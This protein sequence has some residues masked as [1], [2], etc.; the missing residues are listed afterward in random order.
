MAAGFLRAAADIFG[1][2]LWSAANASDHMKDAL[3]G[4]AHDEAFGTAVAEGRAHFHQCSRCHLWICPEAC[5]NAERSMC[6]K[7]APDLATEA[8]AAQ[9]QVAVEQAWEKT[10]KN[11]QTEDLDVAQK[12]VA[13]CPACGAKAPLSGKFC[14]ECGK[15]LAPPKKTACAKCNAKLAEGAKFCAECGERV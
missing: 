5:W 4:K 13:K 7:C 14:G 6:L 8:A 1:G 12:K 9:A 15:P 10:R 11:D 3:R 2:N